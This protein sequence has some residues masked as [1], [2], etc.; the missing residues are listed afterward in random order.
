MG[1]NTTPEVFIIES[2]HPG[3]PRDGEIINNILLMGRRFP[4]YHYVETRDELRSAI[5][6][7]SE[8][9]YRYLH[10]SCHG[11]SDH[12]GFSFGEMY[13][14]EFH[15]LIHQHLQ[16]KRLFISACESVNHDDHQLASLLLR[17]TG[18]YSVIGSYEPIDFDDAVMF[19][20]NFYF[21]AYKNQPGDTIKFT[22]NLVLKITQQLT[23]LYHL[24]INYYSYSNKSKSI[25]LTQYQDG[26]RKN[27]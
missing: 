4:I 26:K 16:D 21:L 25:K 22:R 10:I 14:N 15:S 19:W 6:E 12:F 17:D 7:F 23:G 27:I 8:R 1:E 9:N 20:S 18:C 13:F 2:L 11:S 5:R 24:N 3:D